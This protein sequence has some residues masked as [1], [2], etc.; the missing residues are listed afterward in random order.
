MRGH[1]LHG[2]AGGCEPTPPAARLSSVKPLIA[3]STLGAVLVL[4]GCAGAN[5][6]AEPSASP[7]PSPAAP[8]APVAV[9]ATTSGPTLTDSGQPWVSGKL[10][11]RWTCRCL[12]AAPTCRA[13]SA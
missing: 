12:R 11:T 3:A 10:P 13:S 6:A 4:A 9:A 5:P 2:A 1:A 8:S 7:P